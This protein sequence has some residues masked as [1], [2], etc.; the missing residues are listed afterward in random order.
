VDFQLNEDQQALQEGIRAFCEDRYAFEQ[1]PELEKQPLQRERWSELAEMGVFALRLAEADGGVGLGMAEAVLVFAELGR[2]VV[3]GPLVW[4]HLAAGV[5]GGAADGSTIVGGLDLTHASSDPILVEHCGALDVL[6]VLRADGV[7]RVE[8]GDLEASPVATPLD[9]LTPLH[10][11]ANLPNGERLAGAEEAARLRVLGNALTSA[12]MLGITEATLEYAVEYAKKRE[13]FGRAIAGFQA[14][15]HFCADMYAKQEM[16]RAAVYAAGATLDDPQVGDPL[17]AVASARV[18]ASEASMK[19]ARLCLQIYGGMGYTW[20][21]P[22]HYYLKRVFVLENAFGVGEEYE[23]VVA[24]RI[25]A[26]A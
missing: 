18:V 19:N 22:P 24:S 17:R 16:A 3:P 14:I 6:L 12:F 2:R 5:V 21:M 15:K 13:Q 11:L 23:E 1:V 25:D 9:P 7:Y 10:Q 8:V 20:E 4:S 26:A